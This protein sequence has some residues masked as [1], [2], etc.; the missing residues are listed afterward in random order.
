M[1][2]WMMIE[3]IYGQSCSTP[4]LPRGRPKDY[5]VEVVG[6]RVYLAEAGQR[7]AEWVTA[8]RIESIVNCPLSPQTFRFPEVPQRLAS[9]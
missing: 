7:F 5:L 9:I 6:H 3:T 4:E 2:S 1:I 8:L